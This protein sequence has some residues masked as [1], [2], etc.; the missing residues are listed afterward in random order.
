MENEF[1][2]STS[3]ARTKLSRLAE[4]TV[5][6]YDPVKKSQGPHNLSTTR[7]DIGNY[8]SALIGKL[9]NY[10]FFRKIEA[11]PNSKKIN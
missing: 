3:K 7:R 11:H 2:T 4:D 10:L 6:L 9:L 8:A 5:C 1:S